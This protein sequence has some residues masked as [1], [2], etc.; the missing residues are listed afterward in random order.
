MI[1]T[2][3][4]YD[5]LR[6]PVKKG[7]IYF[8]T[9]MNCLFKDYGSTVSERSRFSA[10]SVATHYIR[11]NKLRPVNG[12]FYYVAE[13]NSLWLYDTGWK[14]KDG[15]VHKYNSYGYQSGVG[16]TPV[17]NTDTS[18]TSTETGDRIIDNNGLLG[19]GSV[20]IRDDNRI[21]RGKISKDK[22]HQELTLASYLDNGISIY[23]YG[24]GANHQERKEVGSLHLGIDSSISNDSVNGTVTRKGVAEYYGDIYIH[25]DVYQ[26]KEKAS[27]TYNLDYTPESSEQMYH[28][29]TYSKMNASTKQVTYTNVEIRVLSKTKA[30]IRELKYQDGIA[31]A[32][33]GDT[34]VALYGS[35]VT[36]ISDITYDAARNISSENVV[37]YSLI[38]PSHTCEYTLSGSPYAA[39][40]T[41][42]NQSTYT[43]DES[44]TAKTRVDV[45]YSV[46]ASSTPSV[47]SFIG[48]W[49]SSP[50]IAG[51]TCK[52]SVSLTFPLSVDS[53][54]VIVN[55]KNISGK[56]SLSDSY[57]L[58]PL[59]LD[60]NELQIAFFSGDNCVI[61]TRCNKTYDINN[62]KTGVLF[63]ES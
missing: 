26:V 55:G 5:L 19:D 13:D 17:I 12:R 58:A 3:T 53:Y 59:L 43:D 9:D 39:E 31:D 38:G 28:K 24:M 56:V 46:N 33:I 23:P 44:I 15:D 60:N 57:T 14:L 18:I 7:Q 62:V 29:F 35:A 8:V 48:V 52:L 2:V 4:Q 10:V 1:C 63:V 21:I 16:I 36:L 47:P 20:V 32:V 54:S 22:T 49:A 37:S 6:L 61:T 34:G 45:T 11:L 41:I 30:L 50:V 25:G 40:V 42:T 51:I 27:T